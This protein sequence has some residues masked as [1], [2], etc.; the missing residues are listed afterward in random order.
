MIRHSE[1]EDRDL[2][3]ALKSGTIRW[4]GH[5]GLRI[6]GRLDCWSG[7]R[8]QRRNR[9]FFESADGAEKCGYR[10]CGHCMKEEYRQWNS[11]RA[12]LDL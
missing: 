6:Y 9:V 1:L 3:R 7:R 5:R 12:S 8:M 10:P 2:W 4:G 11:L